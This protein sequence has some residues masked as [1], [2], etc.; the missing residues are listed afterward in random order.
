MRHKPTNRRLRGRWGLRIPALAT[1]AV[2]ALLLTA[3]QA[4]AASGPQPSKAPLQA[5]SFTPAKGDNCHSVSG[6]ADVHTQ[7]VGLRRSKLSALTP[8]QRAL[9][10]KAAAKRIPI[11]TKPTAGSTARPDQ[12]KQPDQTTTTPTQ[13]GFGGSVV[14]HPDRFTSCSDV[15]W[16]LTT[17]DVLFD[18]EIVI[19][20]DYY[21]ED[22]QWTTYFPD[23]GAWDHGM[24]T[25]S[26][27]GD[28]ILFGGISAEVSSSCDLN[29]SICAASN[30]EGSDPESVEF[31]PGNSIS[32]EWTE[33]DAGP[34]ATTSGAEDYL[35]GFLGA[36]FAGDVPGYP[37]WSFDDEG[38]GLA[39]RCDTIDSSTDS[40]VDEDFTPTLELPI[41]TYGSSAAMVDWAQTNLAGAWGLQGVGAPLNYLAGSV[42]RSN[43][44][45]I[46][47]TTGTGKFVNQ[48]TAIGGD[49][50]S[51]DSCDEFPFAGTY[52]SGALQPGVTNGGACA[53]V[54][55][56]EIAAPTGVLATDWSKVQPI[57]T[58]STSA[59]CVRGHIPLALNSL[60]GTAYSNFIQAERLLDDDQFWVQ[61]LF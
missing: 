11:E 33:L 60:V 50:G 8:A 37:A 46:C 14:N 10:R 9:R 15:P 59:P 42:G 20:G 1:V 48:G 58:F 35:D 30:T 34:A 21:L 53:Q 3:T 16:T 45:I 19:T 32:F 52:Q 51:S 5:G 2:A 47:N 41:D 49:D 22:Q 29:P 38:Y 39:G 26:Y 13:C 36:D 6:S 27:G 40:C 31:T 7:C 17:Y 54:T 25:I 57:G 55:A 61:V 18:G 12:T 4:F 44:A 23:L 43:A 24:T 56:I 28:G